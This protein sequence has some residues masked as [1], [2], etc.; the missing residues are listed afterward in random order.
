MEKILTLCPVQTNEY[1][2]GISHLK[3]CKISCWHRMERMGLHPDK[4]HIWN[5]AD[6][7]STHRWL[8]QKCPTFCSPLLTI[9]NVTMIS[10]RNTGFGDHFLTLLTYFCR[11][12]APALVSRTRNSLA[13]LISQ[14]NTVS[15]TS[16]L[17]YFSLNWQ[18]HWMQ[19]AR[20]SYPNLQI[21]ECDQVTLTLDKA[22]V[23]LQDSLASP[24][25]SSKFSIT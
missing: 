15:S 20:G 18:Q 3:K 22:I 16:W 4:Q 10:F 14:P 2:V 23:W 1:R 6:F 12:P 7:Y 9:L 5:H 8:P 19:T 13:C 11:I 24:T 25:L 21:L 17:A